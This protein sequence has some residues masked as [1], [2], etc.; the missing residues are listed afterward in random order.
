MLKCVLLLPSDCVYV[1]YCNAIISIINKNNSPVTGA[2][3][4]LYGGETS[5]WRNVLGAKRPGANRPDGETSKGRN[6]QGANRPDGETS[7][8]R[9]VQ[10]AKR[11]GGELTKGRNVQLPHRRQLIVDLSSAYDHRSLV[12][13]GHVRLLVPSVPPILNN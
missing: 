3:R 10:G 5:W 9:N 7:R 12:I 4:P 13:S 1:H 2:N 6:V 8:W 11:L